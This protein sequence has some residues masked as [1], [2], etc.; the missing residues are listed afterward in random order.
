MRGAV[1]VQTYEQGVHYSMEDSALLAY[2]A[3]HIMTALERKK[4]Q[5]ELERRVE[6]R[7]QALAT[8]V[9]ELR[10]QITVR[11][12]A[13]QRLQHEALHDALTGLPNRACLLLSLIH[14]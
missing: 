2:V 3:Q 8:A 5:S 4:V 10:E 14:I 6:D 9:V 7:T 13:E 11:E 12:Q 1:V